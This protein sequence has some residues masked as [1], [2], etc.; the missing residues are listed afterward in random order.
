MFPAGCFRQRTYIVQCFVNGVPHW[1]LNSLVFAVWMIF[2]WLWV[3]IEATS[4]F[5]LKCVYLSLPY[6]WS[7]IFYMCHC[8]C[9]CMCV[10]VVSNFTY[11]YFFSIS[12]RVCVLRF[13]CECVSW[14][15]CVCV[16][17]CGS[18]VWYLLVFIFYYIYIWF[19]IK[20]Y[21]GIKAKINKLSFT[22]VYALYLKSDEERCLCVSTYLC[23]ESA[24]LENQHSRFSIFVLT[25]IS[26]F[27]KHHIY[28]Y[29]Y[30]LG[31]WITSFWF[32]MKSNVLCLKIS[33]KHVTESIDHRLSLFSP[34]F[35]Q[36]LN[37]ASEKHVFKAN[38]KSIHF[39]HL[40]KNESAA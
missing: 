4:L 23:K 27:K 2:I 30:I 13:V 32:F 40:H 20:L 25:P 10:G 34:S 31:T 24:S 9:V 26:N 7:L 29:I 28:I 33:K 3:Y 21:I 39:W 18:M 37:S 8:L 17:V 36:H 38:H 11:S 15:L 14:D 5:F 19:L 35:L 1:D 16:F 6:S 22:Q 12:V